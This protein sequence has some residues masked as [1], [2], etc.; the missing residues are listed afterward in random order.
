MI[1]LH[2]GEIISHGNLKSSNCL[3]DSRWVLQ[4]TGFGLHELKGI[5]SK[6]QNFK[7]ME[8][9]SIRGFNYQVN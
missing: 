5:Q 8:H 9:F 6:W 3:V 4:I 7:Q 2:D 1:F